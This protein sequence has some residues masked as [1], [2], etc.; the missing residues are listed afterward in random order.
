MFAI[1][2]ARPRAVVVSAMLAIAIAAVL[3]PVFAAP[4]VGPPLLEAAP[5]IVQV[6]STVSITGRGFVPKSRGVLAF[7]GDSTGMPAYRA[8][9]T[10]S[11]VEHFVVPDGTAVGDHTIEALGP[12][13]IARATVTVVAPGTSVA[14][15]VPTPTDT[16]APT[17]T[18]TQAPIPTLPPATSV[19][20]VFVIVM[21]N[22]AYGQVWNGSATPYT[23]TLAN[24]NARAANYF[25][26][27]HPSLPNYLELYGGSNYGIT[28]NCNP[29][30]TCHT[31]APNLADNLEAAGRTWKGYFEDMP[32]PCYLTDSGGYRAHHNP[33][34]YFDDIRT[35]SA[36]CDANVVDYSALSG[37]L[38]TAASTPSYS[39]IV[40]NN[41][42]NTHDC[43]VATGD[44]WLA[45]NVPPLLTSPACVADTCL[46]VL[47][48][49]ED[50][51][52]QGNRVLTV[53]AGSAARSSQVSTARYDHFSLLRTIE[54][55]LGVP[56][57]TSNDRSATPMS[58]L[59][60]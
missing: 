30:P 22:H 42:H 8:R 40:P 5:S 43:S 3:N 31:N 16:P 57:Q 45:A 29:S 60:R 58:D 28:I 50:D 55:L 19:D 20:H 36:R 34:I 39:M 32:G 17:L 47:T 59:L 25:A 6:G 52:S 37:D 4:F 53:F 1:G 33:F 12:E 2:T 56:S 9:G 44:A 27:S 14:P 13:L 49:D 46:V 26:I 35:D 41:C 11:F 23:T 10:G 54:D 38:A 24:A 15:P 18:P 7:D 21:E 51:G 48:W